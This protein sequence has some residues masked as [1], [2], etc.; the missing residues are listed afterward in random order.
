MDALLQT[1]QVYPA[2]V[3][4]WCTLALLLGGWV[5]G[6][7]GVGLPMI[8]V[9]LMT[10]GLPPYVAAALVVLPV[11]PA[12]FIQLRAGGSLRGKV[13]RFWPLTLGIV[14]GT[15]AG[16]PV[17]LEADQQMLQWLV[18][19]IVGCYALQRMSRY[20]LTIKPAAEKPAGLLFGLFAGGIGGL[21]M[22]IGPL[23]TLYMAAL[24][25]PRDV[26]VG[27][28]A[29]VYLVTTMSI[30]MALATY[31]QLSRPLLI[32]SALAC[33]PA[34][35]GVMAGAWCRRFVSQQFFEKL[36]TGLLLFISVAMLYRSL[37]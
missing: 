14:V 34:T 4:A 13:A 10:F 19:A 27:S 28:I 35:A 7:M 16:A 25:L 23:I 11:F 6:V 15:F 2:T 20:A 18:A 26:F 36:L 29:L 32:A 21:T 24:K 37:Y 3:I 1:G 12:N 9:P 22:L 5:K 8:A 33:I 31:E 30:A 17:L